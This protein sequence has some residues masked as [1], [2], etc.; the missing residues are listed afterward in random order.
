MD[1]GQV[2]F[3]S[4]PRSVDFMRFETDDHKSPRLAYNF[5]EK[6]LIFH[7]E[8][9]ETVFSVTSHVNCTSHWAESLQKIGGV[10]MSCSVNMN[11]RTFVP[12]TV[13]SVLEEGGHMRWTFRLDHLGC[14][15]R[16][17]DL[18]L[19]DSGEYTMYPKILNIGTP[20][21]S[22]SLLPWIRQKPHSVAFCV[23]LGLF[24]FII[25][26]TFFGAVLEAR[27]AIGFSSQ[28]VRQ[29]EAREVRKDIL[30]REKD[31]HDSEEMDK[32]VRKWKVT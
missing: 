5:S 11:E 19:Q 13:C 21:D 6:C 32:L 3:D 7:P 17:F 2:M 12:D 27:G 10:R 25:V 1:F 14:E 22:G 24:L 18:S 9:D 28:A 30:K 8:S 29:A 31:L 20:P 16:V 26:L 23:A 15:S 4:N